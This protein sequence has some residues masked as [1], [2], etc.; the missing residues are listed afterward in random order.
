MKANSYTSYLSY[1][2]QGISSQ[3]AETR[4]IIIYQWISFIK[5]LRI[6][7][8]TFNDEQI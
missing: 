1:K 7:V 2:A 8:T 4:V 3:Q 5:V 6:F